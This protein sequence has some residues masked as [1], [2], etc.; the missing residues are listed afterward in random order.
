M[1]KITTTICFIFYDF[2]G[3]MPDSVT[4]QIDIL[5]FQ[6]LMW[7]GDRTCWCNKS[8]QIANSHD[9]MANIIVTVTLVNEARL[10]P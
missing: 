10:S 9:A 3:P 4:F 1:G 5:S 7:A 8:R 2:Q 6:F